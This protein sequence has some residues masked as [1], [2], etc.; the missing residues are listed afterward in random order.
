MRCARLARSLFSHVR[1]AMRAVHVLP[2]YSSLTQQKPMKP[3]KLITSLSFGLIAF[4]LSASHVHAQASAR[5]V[6]RLFWQDGE[7]NVVRWGDLKQASG[8]WQ[9]DAQPVSG[10]PA[11][12]G[13]R[14]SHVQ[15][16][17]SNGF[18]LTG[19]HDDAEGG[20]QSGW[21]AIKSG[22][23][24]EAHGDHFHWHFNQRPTIFKAVLDTEQGNPAH[25]YEYDGDFYLANDKKNG[26]TRVSS[27]MLNQ[28]GGQGAA[29]FVSAGGGHITLAAVNNQV[30]YSTWIDRDGD[31]LGRV[32]VVGL[33]NS[34]GKRYSFQLPSG[35]IH[36]ATANSGKVFFAPSDGVCWVEADVKLGKRPSDV[37]VH[38]LSLGEDAQGKPKRTGAFNN[39]GGYVLFTTG[40]GAGAELC[41]VDAASVKPSV[42]KVAMDVK[43]GNSLTTPVP[44]VSRTGEP[45]ALLFEENPSGQGGE[46]LHVVALD[47]NRDGRF[48]DAAR[49][50]AIDVGRSQIDGHSGHHEV[51]AIGRRFVVI[52][53]PGDG[54]ISIISTSDWSVQ[55]TLKVGGSPTRL[56]AV[57]G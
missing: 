57:G 47:P 53:N 33:G 32:D 54:E 13:E 7:A 46:K 3:M 21:I 56:V 52:T 9:L 38:H 48:A 29:E 23:T 11:L 44:V 10:Y 37:V 18:V 34:A 25:V 6:A 15:M 51:A 20:F 41:L 40:R 24:Q 22:V 26:F 16:E 35:G 31:N 39:I 30:V 8:S 28:A 49:K 12:D 43:E 55:G 5:T 45:F 14:Q 4:L 36:G 42:T 19:V 17:Y 50:L 2:R 1:F 27:S